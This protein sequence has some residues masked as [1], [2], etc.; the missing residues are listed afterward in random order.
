MNFPSH[1]SAGGRL[2]SSRKR[3]VTGQAGVMLFPCAETGV[4]A[5]WIIEWSEPTMELKGIVAEIPSDSATSS[6]G[7]PQVGQ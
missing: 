5:S 6:R 2:L 4:M 7:C 1:I 3:L